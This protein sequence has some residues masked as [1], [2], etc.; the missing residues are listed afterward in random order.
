MANGKETSYMDG[1]MLLLVTMYW[2][3]RPMTRV[4]PVLIG[5]MVSDT[6]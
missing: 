6:K 4:M 1:T 5:S 2:D 3:G